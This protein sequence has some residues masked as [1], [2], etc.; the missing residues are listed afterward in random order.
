MEHQ[1][2]AH[3]LIVI[4]SANDS[5][6]SCENFVKFDLI[7]PDLT[8][9]ICEH[10]VRHGQKNRRISSNIS[11]YTVVYRFSQSFHYIKSALCAYDGSVSYFP[12]C[13]GTLPWQPNNIVVMKANWYYV[14]SL[15]VRQLWP[16]WQHSF[17]LLLLAIGRYCGAEWAIR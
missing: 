11:G 8:E 2:I 10:Q 1:L 5:C 9:L 12:I 3:L 15:H 4:N 17:L 14:Y 13:Q 16:S 7:T 6:M